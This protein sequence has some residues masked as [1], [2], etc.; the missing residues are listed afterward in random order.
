[1]KTMNLCDFSEVV[2][3]P[4]PSENVWLSSATT[5]TS[6]SKRGTG[7]VSS[8]GTSWARGFLDRRSVPL[9]SFAASTVESGGFPNFLFLASFRLASA[10]PPL[11]PSTGWCSSTGR[12][13]GDFIGSAVQFI[14]LGIVEPKSSHWAFSL[15][16]VIVPKARVSPTSRALSNTNM[17]FLFP[18]ILVKHCFLFPLALGRNTINFWVSHTIHQ[19]RLSIP[20]GFLVNYRSNCA[21]VIPTLIFRNLRCGG[22]FR[23]TVLI[24]G[25]TR[26]DLF[27]RP[28]FIFGRTG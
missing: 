8:S 20:L 22:F 28:L 13:R 18:V 24:L 16:L 14:R 12:P 3:S 7:F 4:R 17:K 27:L 10:P 9:S 6:V 23:A 26:G 25:S 11:R 2:L 15:E 1:M 5:A 19:L 21:E